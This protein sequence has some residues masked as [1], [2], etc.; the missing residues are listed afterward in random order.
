MAEKR[1]FICGAGMLTG[2]IETDKEIFT[3]YDKDYEPLL[4]DAQFK[5]LDRISK[6]A[7]ASAVLALKNGDI[8]IAKGSRNDYGLVLGTQ[9][10]ALCSIH[11]FDMTSVEKGALSVNPA[12][13]PNTVLNSPACQVGIQ[14]SIAGPV[15]TV[16][17]GLN[18]GLDAIGLGFCH[19]KFGLSSMVLAG[20]VDEFSELH[21]FIHEASIP[22][23]EASA[24]VLLLGEGLFVDTLS[25]KM[26]EVVGYNSLT[27]MGENTLN[28]NR[29][30]L[31][32]EWLKQ[33]LVSAG[34]DNQDIGNVSLYSNLNK[35]H[36]MMVLQV[37]AQTLEYDGE[38]HSVNI[39][40]LSASGV[41]QTILMCNRHGNLEKKSKAIILN[42][43]GAR[44]SFLVM[45][46][47][48]NR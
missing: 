14:L 12:H 41:I 5:N 7:L 21:S 33:S 35:V 13:F 47:L 24:F 40:Y 37:I 22:V 43:N 46:V 16:C 28:D 45:D 10:S 6:L 20:G 39:D 36:N 8:L 27:L 2:N 32:G 17:N 25:N 18:S 1:V 15:F 9:Y 23:S 19:I 4:T 34:I 48:M 3:I 31:M 42:V 44:I 26:A 30:V 11:S 29:F 38:I